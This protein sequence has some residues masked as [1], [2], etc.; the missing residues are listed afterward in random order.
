MG[1]FNSGRSVKTSLRDSIGAV[2]NP[3]L[4]PNI[5]NY[6]RIVLLA[7]DQVLRSWGRK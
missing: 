7:G 4:E 1:L 5:Q 3:V 2:P 6:K